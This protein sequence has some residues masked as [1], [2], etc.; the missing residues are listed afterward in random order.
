V[1]F[2]E[3]RYTLK[4]REGPHHRGPFGIDPVIIKM[5]DPTQPS[6]PVSWPRLPPVKTGL[7]CRCPRCARGPLY[8]GLLTVTPRCISCGL[9]LGAHD[10]GDGPAVFVTFILGVLIVPLALWLEVS[11]AP[12]TWVHLAVW[13]PVI[14][15]LAMLMLRLMKAILVAYH[16]QNLRHE[17]DE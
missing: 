17:Y 4:I 1:G 13:P 6:P 5:T 16:F 8:K 14:L 10:S 15:V 3:R 12:P 9:D 2:R 11:M 7:L